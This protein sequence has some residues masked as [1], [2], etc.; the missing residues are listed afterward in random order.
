MSGKGWIG[1]GIAAGIVLLLA[2]VNGP[3]R[4]APDAGGNGKLEC[5]DCHRL[6]NMN[7]NEGVATAQAFCNRCHVDPECGRTVDGQAVSLTVAADAFTDNP[8]RFVACVQCHTDV[9]RSPHQSEAGAQCLSCHSVHGEGDAH[10]PHLR[11]ACQSCHFNTQVVHRDATDNRI[12]PAALDGSGNPVGLTDHRL[13]DV[14]DAASCR[15]CHNAKN[16]VGAPAVVLPE[17]SVLCIVC[18]PS[19]LAVGHG[20]FWVAGAV[21]VIGL[22]LMLRFWFMGRV[23][24]E[25]ASL[26]RK[27]SLSAEAVWDT[28]FSRKIVK[29]VRILLLDVIL[30]RRILKE[31]VQRWSMHSLIFSAMLARFALSLLTGLVFS[32]SP[33]SDLALMLIDKN[34]PATAF[35]YDLLGLFILLGVLWAAIQRY[36]VKPA[37]VVA[38]IEDNITL[39]IV[40]AIAV[41]GFA[42]TGARILL[43]QVPAEIA[44][45]SFIGYSVSRILDVLPLDWRA[46]YPVFWYAHAIAGAAFVAYLPFGKLKH[47]FNV[48]LTYMLEEIAGIKKESRV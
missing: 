12:K 14:S 29:V 32:V 28:L 13:A 16:S 45:Y 44:V 21:L 46:V 38:E 34:H 11:V 33:D 22:L 9:A 19:A 5:L 30:Q 18:H 17:K 40:G 4:N 47:I 8:H 7:T 10:A 24:G 37:H 1:L 41:L 15:R 48:P 2:V 25:A 31:S 23:Q 6:P 42:A 35:A 3:L 27:I 26:R 39:G 20:I 43:T 36:V